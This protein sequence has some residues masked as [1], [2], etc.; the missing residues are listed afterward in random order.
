LLTGSYGFLDVVQMEISLQMTANDRSVLPSI[1][2]TSLRRHWR[3]YFSRPQ[4]GFGHVSSYWHGIIPIL[5]NGSEKKVD[6][7]PNRAVSFAIAA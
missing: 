5:L 7:W 1:K 3:E 4:Q 2:Y 6:T